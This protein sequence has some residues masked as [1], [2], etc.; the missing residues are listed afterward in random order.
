LSKDF[1][2][3]I[4]NFCSAALLPSHIGRA[5]GGSI[6]PRQVGSEIGRAPWDS[7]ICA[8]FHFRLLIR[9]FDYSTN[10]PTDQSVR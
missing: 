6:K 3:C 7:L 10:K 9:H 1:G 5:A 2:R 8:V 4:E